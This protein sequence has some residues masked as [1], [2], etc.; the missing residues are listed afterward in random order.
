MQYLSEQLELR[1]SQRVGTTV[2]LDRNAIVISHNQVLDDRAV[3]VDGFV[4]YG[5]NVQM[6]FRALLDL[7]DA[8][9][10]S[11]FVPSSNTEQPSAAEVQELQQLNNRVTSVGGVIEDPTQEQ[12]PAPV[13]APGTPS[14]N[15]PVSSTSGGEAVIVFNP[16]TGA[17][18]SYHGAAT[19]ADAETEAL[20]IC[21]AGC[22]SVNAPQLEAGGSG[23]HETWAHNGWIALATDGQGHWGTG[24]LHDS[25]A[26]AEQS[27]LTNCRA[28]NNAGNCYVLRSLS[29]FDYQPDQDGVDPNAN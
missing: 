29:S 17:Y 28:A 8:D 1:V 5:Q 2:Q 9:Q 18:A 16:S 12:A 7:T 20:A 15:P 27:A 24:G 3:L 23:I 11:I 22:G 4:T 21:G 13:P 14:T 25:E 6:P 26:D 19:R 10:E